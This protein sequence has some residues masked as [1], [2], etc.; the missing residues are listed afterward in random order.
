MKVPDET[1]IMASFRVVGF[2]GGRVVCACVAFSS[3][4]PLAEALWN[5][6]GSE[7]NASL[8]SRYLVWVDIMA[9]GRRT[10]PS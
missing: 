9:R 10:G 8:A 5:Y 4:E 2:G 6:L 7:Q 3:H 1:V